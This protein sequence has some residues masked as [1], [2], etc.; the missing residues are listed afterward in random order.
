[1]NNLEPGE[2]IIEIRNGKVIAPFNSK[3]LGASGV[4]TLYGIRIDETEEQCLNVGVSTKTL[5]DEILYDVA[6]YLYVDFK[7]L[8]TGTEKYI[9]QFNDSYEFKYVDEQQVAYL[10]SYIALHY[11]YIRFEYVNDRNSRQIEK[12]YAHKN[13]ALYW[14]NGRA[15][16]RKNK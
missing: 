14:R 13:H 2:T 8:E 3:A 10:Y 5:D 9:N 16:G 7:G 15:F 6:C 11:N 4:W 1:M 12:E